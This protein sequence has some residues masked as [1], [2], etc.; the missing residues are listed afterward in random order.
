MNIPE[1]IKLIL[2][3]ASSYV[4]KYESESFSQRTWCQLAEKGMQSPI[5][6]ALYIALMAVAKV[7]FL[8]ESEPDGIESWTPGLTIVPQRK[9]GSYR[10]DFMVGWHKYQAANTG[11]SMFRE[12]VVECD[13]TAFHERTELE[14]RLEKRRD[15]YMQKLGLKV[16]RY[17]G[18]EILSDPYKIAAEIIGYVTDDD[19]GTLTPE[20]YFS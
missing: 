6:H 14:R 1:N 4:G 8:Q 20:Q 9:I 19:E 16:F 17:T 2:D 11:A 3:E 13:S 15:R 18:K 5:E 7:N 12:V 10:A